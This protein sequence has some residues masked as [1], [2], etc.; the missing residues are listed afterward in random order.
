MI[1]SN[2]WGK[3][4]IS[5]ILVAF[6][7]T[8][9]VPVFNIVPEST[10]SA[11]S[12]L[13]LDD[14]GVR[15]MQDLGVRVG[16]PSNNGTRSKLSPYGR[17]KLTF[18]PIAE[19]SVI[20]GSQNL[21]YGHN[22]PIGQ[23]ILTN[24]ISF[25]GVSEMPSNI[26]ASHQVAM[27]YEGIGRRDWIAMY[28]YIRENANQYTFGVLV[29]NPVTKDGRHIYK[30][31]YTDSVI[32]NY[33]ENVRNK[34]SLLT[35]TMGNFNGDEVDDIVLARYS[36]IGNQVMVGVSTLAGPK[37]LQ[38]DPPGPGSYWQCYTIQGILMPAGN[39]DLGV[40][41][42]S[43]DLNGDGIDDCVVTHSR[44]GTS[45]VSVSSTDI[46]FGDPYNEWD[47]IWGVCFKKSMKLSDSA[48]ILGAGNAIGDIDASGR[49]SLIIGGV[50]HPS[51]AMGTGAT[52]W[53]L[54]TPY[55][56]SDAFRV[57]QYNSNSNSFE[58]KSSASFAA[59]LR[60]DYDSAANLA[61]LR[62]DGPD[63]NGYIFKDN[64]I[65]QQIGSVWSVQKDLTTHAAITSGTYKGSMAVAADIDGSHRDS[66]I[67]K[68]PNVSSGNQ[69]MVYSPNGTF[70]QAMDVASAESNLSFSMPNTDEDS[71]WLE[72]DSYSLRYSNPIILAALASAPYYKD[73]SA[74]DEA[75]YME[76]ATTFTT[77]KGKGTGYETAKT[78]T[79][80]TYVSV[81]TDVEIWGITV[82]SAEFEYESIDSL[83][84]AIA[85]NEEITETIGYTTNAG[86]DS[87][88][89][90]S[91]PTDVFKYKIYAPN[92]EGTGFDVE[93]TE[94]MCV[95][96]PY[97][98][99][100]AVVDAKKYTEVA[101]KYNLPNKNIA[102][103]VF[104]HT[105]GY[106]ET[107]LRENEIMDLTDV[108]SAE[109]YMATA[110][111]LSSITQSLEITRENSELTEWSSEV[112]YR[113]GGGPGTM[114]IGGISGNTETYGRSVS[115]TAST[116][117]ET[118]MVNFPPSLAELNCGFYW[119]MLRHMH[120]SGSHSFPVLTY[121]VD[122]VNVPPTLPEDVEIQSTENS[123]TLIWTD[124]QLSQAARD[125]T[126]G[127][128]AKLVSTSITKIPT[129]SGDIWSVTFDGLANDEYYS[130]QLTATNGSERGAPVTYR[131]IKTNRW[132]MGQITFSDYTEV[133]INEFTTEA[134][135]SIQANFANTAYTTSYQWQ[136][137][138]SD[139]ENWGEFVDIPAH[140]VVNPSMTTVSGLASLY[141][142]TVPLTNAS[143]KSFY[144][145]EYRLRVIQHDGSNE[146]ESF[147]DPVLIR[148]EEKYFLEIATIPNLASGSGWYYGGEY[149]TVTAPK[150]IQT[151]YVFNNWGI[152]GPGIDPPSD[153]ANPQT[154]SYIMPN[155]DVTCSPIYNIT[156]PNA[157][158][159]LEVI[160]STVNLAPG[161]SF[162]FKVNVIGENPFNQIYW[163]FSDM[164]TSAETTIDS[165][166]LLTIGADELHSEIILYAR[167]AL[168]DNDNLFFQEFTIKTGAIAPYN[169]NDVRKMQAFLLEF[170]GDKRNYEHLGWDAT[171]PATWVGAMS[172]TGVTW[173]F[174]AATNEQRMRGLALEVDW[175]DNST[176]AYANLGGKLDLSVT[177]V[178]W[179]YLTGTGV[180]S[181]DL[182]EAVS[183]QRVRLF[184]NQ[185]TQLNL[186]GLVKLTSLQAQRNNITNL[187][188]TEYPELRS[189]NLQGTDIS[190]EQITDLTESLRTYMRNSG[191]NQT[192]LYYG[193]GDASTLKT[194][195]KSGRQ[196]EV[197]MKGGPDLEIA[198]SEWDN[199]YPIGISKEKWRSYSSH[200]E[201]HSFIILE[202][203]SEEYYILDFIEP[204]EDAYDEMEFWMMI[205]LHDNIF[206]SLLLRDDTPFATSLHETDYCSFEIRWFNEDGSLAET[207]N[208]PQ[209]YTLYSVS[210]RMIPKEKVAP[211]LL[212][213]KPLYQYLEN[214]GAP[215]SGEYDSE[216][217]TFMF[218]FVPKIT[219]TATVSP[220]GTHTFTAATAG[221]ETQTA[222]TFT[223]SNTG[224]GT[225]TNVQALVTGNGTFEISTV[226]SSA[227]INTG[228][229]ETVSVR[230]I[231]GLAANAEPYTS[232][233]II[234]SGNG[235][236]ISV[237]LSF[238]VNAPTGD[239]TPPALSAGSAN[240]TSDTAAT[241]DFTTDEAGTAYYL[242]IASGAI[243]PTN[244][245]VKAG[246]SLGAVTVG[247]NS[248]KAVTLTAGAR[249]IYV[250]VEDAAHN[251]STP[252]K[253][254]AAAYV[255]P[256]EPK[257]LNLTTNGN[258]NVTVELNRELKDDEILIIAVYDSSK[259][260]NMKVTS[261]T[262]KPNSGT[263][264]IV[265]ISISNGT[266]I[267][268][269]WWQSMNGMSPL[270]G[271]EI[272]KKNGSWSAIGQ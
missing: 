196:I 22:V 128:E 56:W 52:S 229:T 252:L 157:Q 216:T 111:G 32:C 222:Q 204:E 145:R 238:T 205:Y 58:Q 21:L 233:L 225:L 235:L 57:Y 23:N 6:M 241:I 148:S 206:S 92:Q 136:W 101:E 160:D 258:T 54:S 31:T 80:G 165:S 67:W 174:D 87:F 50:T 106:P 211:Y 39:Y 248:S 20:G 236:Y 61:V 19:M 14:E 26:T 110:F 271:A 143:D 138:S 186:S 8:G 1:K 13:P 98:P 94:Y 120:H 116:S 215:G 151:D 62:M 29:F 237:N 166:G 9:L 210:V 257:I 172:G 34:D 65:Y 267:K 161:E 246:T 183:L 18:L 66:V 221:Y 38:G 141:K 95:N 259:L 79:T 41:L 208:L 51:A 213:V 178:E 263:T 25:S 182:S 72:L 262:T 203:Y 55:N 126:T 42:S 122:N 191:E 155:R 179:V 73:M 232:T 68:L 10:V 109:N 247:A 227:N 146:F 265:T 107:Y 30:V 255:A 168:W 180:T 249:D 11:A 139:L 17:D 244:T 86:Q 131:N 270:C 243:A 82:A 253:I 272:I 89:I 187:T 201:D 64:K 100:H 245:A 4:F 171:D 162:Q 135:I 140:I 268:A 154:Q 212:I 167:N 159:G 152:S 147:S 12:S 220:N 46:Y 256:T 164:P 77:G 230:P 47:V 226:L 132:G 254:E 44:Y 45:L 103:H 219:A 190:N 134:T 192:Y 251:I 70:R 43:G 33:F 91:Y 133:G 59:S 130:V 119:K 194:L 97:K 74:H 35:M 142:L 127:Y 104:T 78:A 81:S 113:G 121:I 96:V 105:V 195:Y 193:S 15:I 202:D 209:I 224:T 125:A 102:S 114:I 27:D 177:K 40:S 124:S 234:I 240:R 129:K 137:R 218:N 7:L 60:P 250:V 93:G 83:T 108:Y 239:T 118:E 269:M 189:V 53:S 170:S 71:I 115:T 200:L 3:K 261:E 264:Y 75:Q 99:V 88:V 197:N 175:Y 169:Q 112:T 150:V 231:T 144:M 199:P 69:I 153:S 90:Y 76:S 207:D 188:V 63:T 24:P 48:Y 156:N 37:I 185:I 217:L 173:F 123:I 198:N 85:S 5:L 2:T 149:V 242:V 223:I 16:L 260:L 181:V 266:T 36:V 117:Y 176:K 84:N 49:K 228:D 158:T 163:Y 184:N 214:L 28:Y